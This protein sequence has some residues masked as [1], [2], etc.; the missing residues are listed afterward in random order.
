MNTWMY[1][2]VKREKHIWTLFCQQY[3]KVVFEYTSLDGWK[4]N[5][6]AMVH[7]WKIYIVNIKFAIKC[8]IILKNSIKEVS[9][10]R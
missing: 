3:H 6:A 10:M 2:E 7:Q 9:N 1:A 4:M 8:E 5:T